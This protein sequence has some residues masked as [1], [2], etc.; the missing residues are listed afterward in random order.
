MSTKRDRNG[1]P[2]LTKEQEAKEQ[3]VGRVIAYVRENAELFADVKGVDEAR[4]AVF[5]EKAVEFVRTQELTACLLDRIDKQGLWVETRKTIK[6]VFARVEGGST[7]IDAMQDLLA[8]FVHNHAGEFDE[9]PTGLTDAE[10]DAVGPN[11]HQSRVARLLRLKMV[12]DDPNRLKVAQLSEK[13]LLDEAYHNRLC[14]PFVVRQYMSLQGR[15][16]GGR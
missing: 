1:K 8:A 3:E 13:L 9:R 10:L 15:W 2:K 16:P 5:E 12:R 6:R 4:R 7:E 11:G 14:V